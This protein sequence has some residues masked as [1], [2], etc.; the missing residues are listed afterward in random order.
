MFAHAKTN[1]SYKKEYCLLGDMQQPMFE[2]YSGLHLTGP[3]EPGGWGGLEP[4]ING[5]TVVYFLYNSE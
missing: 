4:P 2:N 3:S 1:I 5:Q